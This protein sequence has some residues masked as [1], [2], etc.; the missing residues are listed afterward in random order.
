MLLPC[1]SY[2]RGMRGQLLHVSFVTT[3]RR[4][5]VWDL[6]RFCKLR[7]HIPHLNI[8][9]IVSLNATK[10]YFTN[11]RVLVFLI[12]SSCVIL[13]SKYNTSTNAPCVP[14]SAKTRSFS[15]N[16]NFCVIFLSFTQNFERCREIMVEAVI[17]I[18][19]TQ[20]TVKQH[21]KSMITLP[22][23]YEP[24]QDLSVEW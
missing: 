7:W 19:Y 12:Y 21:S 1:G 15:G 24:M 20:Y 4:R 14:W 6:E 9:T 22:T 3:S 13:F 10:H 8:L 18:K 17:Q 16:N 2:L 11:P 23:V 5:M